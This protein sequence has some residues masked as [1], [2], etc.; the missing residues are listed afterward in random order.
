MEGGGQLNDSI[1]PDAR[2][3]TKQC[4]LMGVD[5]R[6]AARW[7]R[8]AE[9]RGKPAAYPVRACNNQA[10]GWRPASPRLQRP[11]FQRWPHS[12][13]VYLR[14]CVSWARQMQEGCDSAPALVKMRRASQPPHF[15]QSRRWAGSSLPCAWAARCGRGAWERGTQRVNLSS[16]RERARGGSERIAGAPR[17]LRRD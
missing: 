3:R 14:M 12:L 2:C 4:L 5:G 8:E 7:A 10:P 9:E 13:Q 17:G 6:A 16:M 11:S 1:S 15:H